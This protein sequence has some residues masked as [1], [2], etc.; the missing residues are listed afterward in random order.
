MY[1]RS[2]FQPEPMYVDTCCHLSAEGMRRIGL[3]MGELM[4][5]RL[6][7]DPE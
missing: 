7:G 3:R 5:E 2:S 1:R 4:A 6:R